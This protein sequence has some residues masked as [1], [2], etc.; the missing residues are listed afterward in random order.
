M[1]FYFFRCKDTLFSSIPPNKTPTFSLHLLFPQKI[2][3]Q[4]DEMGLEADWYGNWNV[5][6]GK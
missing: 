3:L 4:A 2:R 1:P 5:R 6:G